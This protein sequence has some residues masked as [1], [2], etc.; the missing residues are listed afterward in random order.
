[1]FHTP[2]LEKRFIKAP[3]LHLAVIDIFIGGHEGEIV[4]FAE[5]MVFPG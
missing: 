5:K 4:E 3:V 1:M 2:V